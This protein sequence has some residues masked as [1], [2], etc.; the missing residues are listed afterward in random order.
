MMSKEQPLIP[1]PPPP[2]TMGDFVVTVFALVVGTSLMI[3]V[4]GTGLVAIIRPEQK[5]AG[6]IAILADVLTTL[7][8]ALIGY[9]AGRGGNREA[10]QR[11]KDEVPP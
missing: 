7:I 3:A 4:I 11:D 1:R 8:G 2:K 5:I 10:E 9:L 6:M